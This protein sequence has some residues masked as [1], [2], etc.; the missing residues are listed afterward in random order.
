MMRNHPGVATSGDDPGP[1]VLTARLTLDD[2]VE[3]SVPK[4][5]LAYSF[6]HAGLAIALGNPRIAGAL[7]G[8]RRA[9]IMQAV[10]DNWETSRLWSDLGADER[11]LLLDG[12]VLDWIGAKL[13]DEALAGLA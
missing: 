8:D 2:Q 12:G 5:Y 10:V 13:L 4:T 1:G 7:W 9:R 3:P 6:E 11:K